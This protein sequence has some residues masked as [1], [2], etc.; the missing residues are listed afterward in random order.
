MFCWA[1]IC[2]RHHY[3]AHH[4]WLLSKWKQNLIKILL[5]LLLLFRSTIARRSRDE[6][7]SILASL[8]HWM[9]NNLCETHKFDFSASPLSFLQ[10]VLMA[11]SQQVVALKLE[12]NFSSFLSLSLFLS[13]LFPLSQASRKG[14]RA[15]LLSSLCLPY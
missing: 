13:S 9:S 7:H 15:F 6:H 11:I 1:R 3:H 5:L 2:R 12:F 10:L 4:S 14:K 8:E